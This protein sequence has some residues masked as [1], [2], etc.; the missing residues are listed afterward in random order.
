METIRAHGKF[1]TAHR[2]L[3][4][5]GKCAHVHGHTWRGTFAIRT[6]RF[7]RDEKLDM[8]V[9]FGDLKGVFKFLDHKM[10]ISERDRVFLESGLFDPDG[11]VVIPG[12]NPSVENVSR[13][14]LDR[15]VEVLRHLF[16]GERREYDMEVTIQETENNFF[17]LCEKLVIE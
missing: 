5:D 12:K 15:G 2:Q 14:C 1:H 4:Y 6:E 9:D 3:D 13:Y 16:P 7:P 17:T 10:L 8:T 11:I